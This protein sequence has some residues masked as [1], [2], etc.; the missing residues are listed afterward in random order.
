MIC[1]DGFLKARARDAM[2]WWVDG[3]DHCGAGT[4]TESAG[5]VDHP[6]TLIEPPSTGPVNV[7][8]VAMLPGGAGGVLLTADAEAAAAEVEVDV[9]ADSDADDDVDVAVAVAVAVALDKLKRIDWAW[10][11]EIVVVD[12]LATGAEVTDAWL[13]GFIAL[14]ASAPSISGWVSMNAMVGPA[15]IWAV[16][17][18]MTLLSKG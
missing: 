13:L 3:S 15:T 16:P 17:R 7:L 18:S 1:P 12:K 9:D 5:T 2:R 6:S 10:S 8:M 11:G 4:G 14:R